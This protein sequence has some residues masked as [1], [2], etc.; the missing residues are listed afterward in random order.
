M[1]D[2]WKIFKMDKI[3]ILVILWIPQPVGTLPAA[4]FQ[5]VQHVMVCPT[6]FRG[7]FPKRAVSAPE[8]SAMHR[9]SKTIPD[10][11]KC[12]NISSNDNYQLS[13]LQ[14]IQNSLARTV[15]KAPKSC[16][17]TPIL[18]SLHWLRITERIKYKLLSLTYKVLTT[19]QPSITKSGRKNDRHQ[20]TNNSGSVY[21]NNPPKG[22]GG[23]KI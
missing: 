12:S 13:C 21:R 14:H 19:T 10:S 7:E 15:M 3:C 11:M 2:F 6:V 18:R 8:I 16:H 4:A 1:H 5:L 9:Y 23:L 20:R 17:I 22:S